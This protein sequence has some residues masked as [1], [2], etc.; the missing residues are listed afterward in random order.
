MHVHDEVTGEKFPCGLAFFAFLD[1]GN[2]LSRDE[3]F[4]DDVAHLLGFNALLDIILDLVLL[5]GEY[6]HNV[7]LILGC[8]CLGHIKL[9][10]TSKEMDDVNE[11]K[12]EES[13]I[14]AEQDH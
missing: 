11:N 13:D 7:P 4:V 1:F 5:A 9:V 10:N 6:V 3:H 2:A 14:T 8:E 12:I